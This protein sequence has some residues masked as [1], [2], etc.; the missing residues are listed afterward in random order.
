M[1]VCF[2]SMFYNLSGEWSVWSVPCC[3]IL[4]W[5][6]FTYW[7]KSSQIMFCSCTARLVALLYWTLFKFDFQWWYQFV[8]PM[9]VSAHYTYFLNKP[10][11][12][13]GHFWLC[14]CT[15][16]HCSIWPDLSP[17]YIWQSSWSGIGIRYLW[18]F[19]VWLEPSPQ[20]PICDHGLLPGL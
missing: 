11:I 3:I 13:P 19:S 18:S 16:V 20:L 9:M 14:Y 8:A 2:Y 7:D 15:V 12:T 6:Y 1:L 17:S 10:N 5:I 4:P